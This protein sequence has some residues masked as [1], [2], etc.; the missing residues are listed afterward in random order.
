MSLFVDWLCSAVCRVINVSTSRGWRIVRTAIELGYV[1][2]RWKRLTGGICC[3]PHSWGHQ[4]NDQ[5]R[6]K[7]YR[8]T[9]TQKRTIEKEKSAAVREYV[10]AVVILVVIYKNKTDSCESKQAPKIDQKWISEVP[11][12]IPIYLKWVSFYRVKRAIPKMQHIF[13]CT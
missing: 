10:K 8:E 2:R 1:K 6:R 4:K 13:S 9:N 5:K 3:I 12:C 11:E 7:K